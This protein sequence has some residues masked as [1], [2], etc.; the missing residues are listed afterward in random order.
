M[1]AYPST[2]ATVR[3]LSVIAKRTAT[4]L[5]ELTD[6]IAALESG[7]ELTDDQADVLQSVV[8]RSRPAVEAVV[9][10]TPESTVTPMSLLIKQLDLIA[11]N[12]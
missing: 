11:K 7:T 6:A 12:L 1:A 2:S 3:N 8:D 9:D 10:A 4:D 5:D